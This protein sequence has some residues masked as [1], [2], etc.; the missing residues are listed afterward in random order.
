MKD[1]PDL[2]LFSNHP[3]CARLFSFLQWLISLALRTRYDIGVV[4]RCMKRKWKWHGVGSRKFM[5]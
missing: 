2:D 5:G 1:L 3:I 4:L